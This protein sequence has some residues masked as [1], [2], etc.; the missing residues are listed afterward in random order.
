[1]KLIE[2]RKS[3]G[4]AIECELDLAEL[5]ETQ[6]ERQRFDTKWDEFVKS[7]TD[8]KRIYRLRGDRLQYKS[9]QLIPEKT[10]SRPPLLLVLGN[11]ATHS[12]QSGMFFAFKGNGREHRFW[13]NI[14]K[15]SG[16]LSLPFDAGLPA[17]EL[18]A[19][20]RKSLS[21]LNYDSEF[22]IGL[23]VFISMPSA[24]G[25]KWGG[26]AGVQ[27]LVGARAF[28]KI[29]SA[30][31][32][33]VLRCIK[34]FV[35]PHGKGAVVAFQKN[36]WNALSSEDDLEYSIG[37]AKAGKLKG[38]VAGYPKTPFFCVPPT[39]LSGPCCRV[40]KTFVSK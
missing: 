9:E 6:I 19:N 3:K 24:P 38:T 30:E 11:P 10:D 40:L 32:K 36:A 35:A 2:Q 28:R 39:R 26:I 14:L 5:F 18:N 8:N 22:C 29:E 21:G 1:M 13:K 37:A 23:S 7:D 31:R 16:L 12:V 33:R 25:G 20:R 17:K 34:R 15:P 4:C 27:R